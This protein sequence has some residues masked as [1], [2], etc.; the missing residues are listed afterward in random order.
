[1][2]LWEVT[3]TVDIVDR[4]ILYGVLARPGLPGWLT[5]TYFK[6]HARVRGSIKSATGIGCAL[7]CSLTRYSQWPCVCLGACGGN[8][9]ITCDHN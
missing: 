1:M 6:F 3:T 4:G 8:L 9:A 5:P 7:R 2:S